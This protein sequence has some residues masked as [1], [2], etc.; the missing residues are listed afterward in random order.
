[1]PGTSLFTESQITA[2]DLVDIIVRYYLK[3][4]YVYDLTTVRYEASQMLLE[5]VSHLD[6]VM[7]LSGAFAHYP[8]LCMYQGHKY[9]EIHSYMKKQMLMTSFRNQLTN[10]I[11]SGIKTVQL[12]KII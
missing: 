10:L 1:M 8:D 9:S 7:K 12:D 6:A 2:D 5:F 4:S 11:A 3:S